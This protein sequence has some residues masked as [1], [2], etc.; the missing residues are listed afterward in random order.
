MAVAV[1]RGST[2]CASPQRKSPDFP[3]HNQLIMLQYFQM[4]NSVSPQLIRAPVVRKPDLVD[5]GHP[6]DKKSWP[7]KSLLRRGGSG[8]FLRERPSSVCKPFV[9]RSSI[10]S[11]VSITPRQSAYHPARQT[12]AGVG[13][14][15]GCPL[16][17]PPE[18]RSRVKRKAERP[19]LP[20]PVRLKQ[21]QFRPLRATLPQITINDLLQLSP[22][23]G[24][25]ACPDSGPVC[26]RRSH[27]PECSGATAITYK[28]RPILTRYDI[29]VLQW[30]SV[31][32]IP[33]SIQPLYDTTACCVVGG[34]AWN[35][36][37]RNPARAKIAWSSANV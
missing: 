20:P 22:W 13:H 36:L 32:A 27:R 2:S 29:A 10:F 28:F 12:I 4:R 23:L 24:G 17:H 5:P 7:E 19:R 11:P 33:H 6:E 18:P 30:E 31:A 35:S 15:S 14:L 1:F 3:H 25:T 9:Q 8:G 26:A 34:R 21:G 37:R 16:F